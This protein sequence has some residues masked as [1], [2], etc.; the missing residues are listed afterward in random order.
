MAKFVRIIASL[1]ISFLVNIHSLLELEL[2]TGTHKKV[3]VSMQLTG[4]LAK[5]LGIAVD[6]DLRNSGEF[7]IQQD[8]AD[9]LV[10]IQQLNTTDTSVIKVLVKLEDTYNN[11]QLLL[12]EFASN[13]QAL[14]ALSHKISDCIYEHVTGVPG[15]FSTKIAFVERNLTKASTFSYRLMVADYDGANQ[16]VV[17]TSTCPI[18]SISWS[19]CG[20]MLAF[21]SFENAKAEIY[22]LDI[23]SGTRELIS[24]FAGING[25]PKFSP[26]GDSLAMA[27][28]KNGLPSIYKYSF[29]H[30]QLRRLTFGN[31]IDTE[32]EWSTDGKHIFFTSNRNG[33]IQIYKLSLASEKIER[34]TMTGRYNATAQLN[35]SGKELLVLHRNKQ[36]FNIG[37]HDLIG[38]TLRAVTTCGNIQSP[39]ISPNGK[40]VLFTHCLPAKKVLKVMPISGGAAKLLPVKG[41]EAIKPAW[42]PIMRK[43]NVQK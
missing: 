16:Q 25:A 17:F 1:S 29:A 2:T 9:F 28:A 38:N 27:L 37:V 19:P 11:K 34:I 3:S 36:G 32:P 40:M 43:K 20:K 33:Q 5:T 18:M 30:K 42:G 24:S 7:V 23:L 31:S 15:I 35:V 13:S 21:V 6:K 39:S 14:S 4:K 26:K 41:N 8:A 12:K 10:S 22:T